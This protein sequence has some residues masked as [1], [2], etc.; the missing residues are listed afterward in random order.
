VQRLPVPSSPPDIWTYGVMRTGVREDRVPERCREQNALIYL[1]FSGREGSRLLKWMRDCGANRG[2]REPRD[3]DRVASGQFSF[4]LHLS[5]TSFRL[6]A[7]K[8]L[9]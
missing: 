9:Q 7:S 3:N 4:N 5:R 2:L 6:M 1:F 8:W